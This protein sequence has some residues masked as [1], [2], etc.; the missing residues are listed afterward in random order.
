MGEELRRLHRFAK[1]R[2]AS[3]VEP[4]GLILTPSQVFEVTEVVR[5]PGDER[6]PDGQIKVSV[7]GCDTPLRYHPLRELSKV[8]GAAEWQAYEDWLAGA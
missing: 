3:R 6:H 4:G 1:K 8:V 2:Y 5:V 7:V